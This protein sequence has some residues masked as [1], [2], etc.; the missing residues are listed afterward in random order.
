MVLLSS[1]T[2]GGTR[3]T[4]VAVLPAMA[5]FITV[6]NSREASLVALLPSVTGRGLVRAYAG[7]PATSVGL[8]PNNASILRLSIVF[9]LDITTMPPPKDELQLHSITLR[10]KLA[11]FSYPARRQLRL[12]RLTAGR[13]APR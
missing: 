1:A 7:E 12:G 5:G 4:R 13:P 8:R 9:L 3:G 11:R 6:I 10:A 2:S